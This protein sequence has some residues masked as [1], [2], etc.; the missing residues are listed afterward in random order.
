MSFIVTEMGGR[1]TVSRPSY[2]FWK[3]LYEKFVNI[4]E[5][6]MY[7]AEL[8]NDTKVLQKNLKARLN[9]YKYRVEE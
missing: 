5:K 2:Y 9:L 8:A 4:K 6:L 1:W 7:D 3:G